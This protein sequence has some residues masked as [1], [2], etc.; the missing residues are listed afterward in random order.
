[1]AFLQSLFSGQN[2]ALT[3]VWVFLGLAAILIASFWLFRKIAG[4]RAL[5]PTR[6]RAP[7]L[8]VTDAAIV[9]D[10]RR[11][12]LVRR[13]NVEHLVMI[14]GPADI[15]IEQNIQRA[16]PA[17]APREA[18]PAYREAVIA[19][20]APPPARPVN[21]ELA[22]ARPRARTANGRGKAGQEYDFDD[23]AETMAAEAEQAPA[24]SA[25]SPAKGAVSS[26]IAAARRGRAEPP[27]QRTTIQAQATTPQK[28]MTVAVQAAPATAAAAAAAAPDFEFDLA[29]ELQRDTASAASAAIAKVDQSPPVQAAISFEDE[30]SAEMAQDFDMPR[31][32][33]DNSQGSY[34]A[35]PA[36]SN[37]RARPEEDVDDE[38][39]R[40]LKELANA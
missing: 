28:P 1:M 13:D 3:L 16:Q 23:A 39:Q 36:S 6:S 18:A 32:I 29:S 19:A 35:G 37:P 24:E 31:Q 15:V 11:L 27:V 26:I 40:L 34:A 21:G 8:A 9:D 10:K 20:E 12:V 5:K 2:P 4:A 22:G 14:G 25:A 38:M 17:A 7:R 33:N 30:L